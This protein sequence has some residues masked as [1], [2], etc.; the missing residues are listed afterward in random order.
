[1]SCPIDKRSLC[2][3]PVLEDDFPNNTYDKNFSTDAG[4]GFSMSF[5]SWA[6]GGHFNSSDDLKADRMS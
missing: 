5:K 2:V 4:R 6:L 1:M 3:R